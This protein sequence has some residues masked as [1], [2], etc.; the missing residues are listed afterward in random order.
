MAGFAEVCAECV[1]GEVAGDDEREAL[2]VA[3]FDEPADEVGVV[4]ISSVVLSAVC[5]K[6][7]PW[8]G[9]TVFSSWPYDLRLI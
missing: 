7:N 6:E 3:V 2:G 4:A 5:L 1:V 9:W 8:I